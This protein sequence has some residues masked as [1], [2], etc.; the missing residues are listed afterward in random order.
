MQHVLIP[1]SDQYYLKAS[2]YRTE[3]PK[4][5]VQIIHGA[6]EHK[7]RYEEVA[8]YLREA[9]F[10]VLVSDLRG[11]G[12]STDPPFVSGFMP[13][14]D[15]L[16]D[17]QHMITR[18][19]QTEF[20]GVPIVLL[21]HSFGANIARLYLGRHDGDVSALVMSGA[22]FFVRGISLAIAFVRFL[23]LFISPHGYLFF[24]SK[25][26]TNA[27]PQWVC[28]DPA[29]IEERRRDPYRKNFRYQV[30]S[31]LTIFESIRR[32]HCYTEYT[33][34]NPTLPILFVSG[35]EDPI[36]GGRVGLRDSQRSLR[37]IGYSDITSRVF[38]H[39]RHE[40]L[41]EREKESVFD[42]II[43]FFGRGVKQ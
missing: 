41:M 2:L 20:E 22:P 3:Q 7:G 32:L 5:V 13:P 18:F 30:A 31:I 34:T 23:S 33:V 26:T 10:A 6:S 42:L 4:A 11:H 14:V 36:S 21:A 38:D 16:V 27:S 39:M 1:G 37:R 35:K 17:D 24:T 40:V 8:R 28:S 29:V 19:L 9:G 43:S 15:V 25:L 12:Q